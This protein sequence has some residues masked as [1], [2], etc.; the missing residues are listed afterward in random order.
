[1]GRAAERGSWDKTA[2]LKPHV[3]RLVSPSVDIQRS[4]Y[5]IVGRQNC[6]ASRI[7]EL[8]GDQNAT[9]FIR[10]ETREFALTSD[11]FHGL[12]K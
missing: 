11:N 1:M 8:S 3:E 12:S 2:M 7:P 9:T 4:T 10:P 6:A 5:L